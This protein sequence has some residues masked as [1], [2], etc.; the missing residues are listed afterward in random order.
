MKP[1]AQATATPLA[2]GFPGV[3]AG[4]NDADGVA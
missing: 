3:R 2:N 4:T 1:G